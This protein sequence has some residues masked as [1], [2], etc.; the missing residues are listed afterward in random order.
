MGEMQIMFNF[1]FV[2]FHLKPREQ[3]SR[4]PLVGTETEAM[5]VKNKL[6]ISACKESV[7]HFHCIYFMVLK[8]ILQDLCV[9]SPHGPHVYRKKKKKKKNIIIVNQETVA[10]LFHCFV[11]YKMIQ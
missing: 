10:L 5:R 9:A 8:H 1:Y 3:E 4:L 6:Y 11:K 7:L 2:K